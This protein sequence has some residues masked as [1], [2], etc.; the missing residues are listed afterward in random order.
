MTQPVSDAPTEDDTNAGREPKIGMMFLTE[1]GAYEFYVRYAGNV[2]FNVCKGWWEKSA[3]N[4]TKS[5]VFVCSKEGFRPKNSVNDTKKPR[6]EKRT[7]CP[8]RMAIKITPSGKYSVSEFVAEHNHQ[9]ETPLGIQMLKSQKLLAEVKPGGRENANLIPADYK[10]YLRS[11]HTKNML[12]GDAGAILE[13]LQKMKGENPSFFYAIQ[14][15]EDDQLT[16]FFWADARSIMDYYYFGDVVCFDTSYIANDYGRP[17][18]LFIGVNHH[19]QAVLFGAALLYDESIESFKWLFETLRTAMSGKLPK[20]VLVDQ[21]AAIGDAVAAVWPG[22]SCR[23]C[24]WHMYQNLN[25]HVSQ[26]I[27]GS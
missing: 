13:Y 16:N 26:D 24:A 9:L 11:K 15:D 3:R 12:M 1:D 4:V 21:C 23:L 6:P 8:A 2:G 7:C 20:T 25:K 27:L 5:R 14:V 17:F 22:T 10:N 19:K 18:S